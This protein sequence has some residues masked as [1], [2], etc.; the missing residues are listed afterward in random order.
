M[1]Q[2]SCAVLFVKRTKITQMDLFESDL[3]NHRLAQ[4]AIHS[5]SQNQCNFSTDPRKNQR[6][7]GGQGGPVHFSTVCPYFPQIQASL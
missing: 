3:P 4:H 1:D 5:R 7:E 6:L 2:S